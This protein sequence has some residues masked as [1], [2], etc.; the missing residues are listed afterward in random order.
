MIPPEALYCRFGTNKPER[1]YC[2]F[3][4]NKPVLSVCGDLAFALCFPSELP[5]RIGY[6]RFGPLTDFLLSVLGRCNKQS[7]R[8]HSIFTLRIFMKE[9]CI[10]EEERILTGEPEPTIRQSPNRQHYNRA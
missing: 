3:G 4:T 8:S 7:S 2:R 9:R 5:G 6:C 10:D 1:L